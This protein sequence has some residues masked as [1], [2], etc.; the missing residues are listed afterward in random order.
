MAVLVAVGGLGV[1]VGTGVLVTVAVGVAVGSGV[2]VGRGVWVGGRGVDVNCDMRVSSAITVLTAFCVDRAATVAATDVSTAPW[3]T[4]GG[5]S[6]WIPQ[7]LNT[8][9]KMV[10]TARRI[11]LVFIE[12]TSFTWTYTQPEKFRVNSLYRLSTRIQ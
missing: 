11:Y 5:V 4:T 12:L 3:S 1:A 6:V 9:T 7:L 2:A 8:T 10:T